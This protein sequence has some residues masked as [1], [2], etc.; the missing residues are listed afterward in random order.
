MNERYCTYVKRVLLPRHR[1]A[2]VGFVFLEAGGDGICLV[3]ALC[4]SKQDC[5][6]VGL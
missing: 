3:T 1:G 4:S 2:C 6:F 5:E